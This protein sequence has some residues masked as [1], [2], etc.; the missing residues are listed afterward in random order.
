M[1]NKRVSDTERKQIQLD[2]LKEIDY[3]CRA[4]CIRYSL[5]FGTA[6]GAV[7]HKGFI[8]WDD[9]VDIVMPLSDMRRFRDIFH[10]DMILYHDIDVDPS[11][12]NAFSR[13]SYIPTY[14][15][16]GVIHKTYGVNIDLYPAVG[17]PETKE[18]VDSFFAKIAKM[19]KKRRFLMKW[20]SRLMRYFPVIGIPFF[21]TFIRKYRDMILYSYPYEGSKYY[22]HAGRTVWDNVFDFNIFD[23]LIEADFEDCKLLLSARYHDYLSHCYGDYMQLPPENQR[24]PYHGGDYYW[25][26]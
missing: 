8:P 1:K 14:R 12:T 9:D 24:H 6:L 20:R 17:L 19:N 25:K 18:D 10:S 7:R 5:A 23:E 21:G 11:Y 16:I 22:L 26:S 2:M 3:F 13:L 15:K 4:N